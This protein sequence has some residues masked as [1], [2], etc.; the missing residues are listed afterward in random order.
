MQQF[1]D[2]IC[3][4]MI[5]EKHTVFIEYDLGVCVIVFFTLCVSSLHFTA[6]IH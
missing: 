5:L 2:I 4:F 3:S 1:L 6:E